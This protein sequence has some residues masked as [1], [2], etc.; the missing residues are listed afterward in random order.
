MALDK[1][2]GMQAN[3][4]LTPTSAPTLSGILNLFYILSFPCLPPCF[5]SPHPLLTW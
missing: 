5:V 2:K 1:D 3:L 4:S